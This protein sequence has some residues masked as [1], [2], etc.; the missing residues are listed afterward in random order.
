MQ[1]CLLL[2]VPIV[3]WNTIF[4]AYLPESYFIMYKDP[5]IPV[6][7]KWVENLSLLMIFILAALMPLKI[8]NKKQKLG[9]VIYSLGLVIYLLAWRLLIL[10]PSG[11]WSSSIF[12]F[13][14]L[15][16]TPIILLIGIGLIGEKLYIKLK[17]HRWV[18]IVVS[19]LFIFFRTWHSVL[20]FTL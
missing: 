5:D 3:V 11:E 13:T 17:Y 8:K 15:T 10:F 16:Y 18:F 1:N 2:L 4:I 19:F 14:S 7:I 9:I 12:G 20:T 6:F